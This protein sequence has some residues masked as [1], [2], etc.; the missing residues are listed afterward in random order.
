ML[1][2]MKQKISPLIE[3]RTNVDYY[4]S[5][6]SKDWLIGF[7]EAEGT[8]YGKNGNQIIFS[9]SQHLSDYYLILAIKIYLKVGKIQF[10]FRK[11]GR[12]GVELV[13]NNKEELIDTIIPLISNQL[14]TY[15]KWEQFNNWLKDNFHLSSTILNTNITP[16]WLT[17]FVDGDG[18]FFVKINKSK[19]HIVGYNVR[20]VFDITQITS[21]IYL[22]KQIDNK[23]LQNKGTYSQ[24]GSVTHLVISD[25][26][27]L[28]TVV[29]PFFIENLILTRKS[30]DFLLWREI[31]RIIEM[32]EHR[33]Q[34]GLSK[35]LELRTL[36][37]FHRNEIHYSILEEIRPDWRD[38]LEKMLNSK[39]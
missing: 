22:L 17:G 27:T 26:K 14:R 32:K 8:F 35:I 10:Y 25:F 39:N 23:Y 9:I 20:A 28:I 5:K 30:I 34:S 2:L 7:I 19:T 36:Q 31:L 24:S 37:Q 16:E 18:S 33:I 13:V 21:E 11:D 29:E 1:E 12:L 38:K 3:Q 15:K 4:L 6:L